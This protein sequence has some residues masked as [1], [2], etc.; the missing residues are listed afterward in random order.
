MSETYKVDGE[1]SEKAYRILVR[2]MEGPDECDW[3]TVG[4]LQH[5]AREFGDTVIDEPVSNDNPDLLI[6]GALNLDDPATMLKILE[7]RVKDLEF[8]LRNCETW[9]EAGA[10]FLKLKRTFEHYRQLVTGGKI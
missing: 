5:M 8:T 3:V 4:E 10:E 6:D 7:T 1:I 9:V 2:I